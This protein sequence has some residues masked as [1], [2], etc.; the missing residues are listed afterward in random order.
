MT[1]VLT[2]KDLFF[3]GAKA[4]HRVNK[5][6]THGIYYIGFLWHSIKPKPLGSGVH[7][8]PIFNPPSPVGG[9]GGTYESQSWLPAAAAQ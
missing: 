6:V 2:G 3:G 5:Q 8:S 9:T 4:K 7:S 1:I